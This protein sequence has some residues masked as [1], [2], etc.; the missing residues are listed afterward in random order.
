M[1]SRNEQYIDYYL[2][3]TSNYGTAIGHN[4]MAVA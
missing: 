1:L 4:G 2:A 3:N